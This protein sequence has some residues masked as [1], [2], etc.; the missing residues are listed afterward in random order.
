[1][2]A[3]PD[4][5]TPRFLIFKADHVYRGLLQIHLRSFYP[6]AAIIAVGRIDEARAA[7]GAADFKLVLMGIGAADGDGLDLIARLHAERIPLRHVLVVTARREQRLLAALRSLPIGGF[8]DTGTED[9]ARL[10]VAI[11][12][13][14]AGRRLLEPG[15]LGADASDFFRLGGVESPADPCRATRFGGH[16]GMG[17][18]IR[19][20][21]C[22]L[23]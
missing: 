23:G 9:L 5:T 4:F 22:G 15:H 10:G 20:P 7:L 1:M 13:I 14:L 3:P 17:A 2:I 6:H 8:F 21:P 19:W 18:T 12:A 16:R 11:D